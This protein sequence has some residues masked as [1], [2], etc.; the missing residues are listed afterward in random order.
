[1]NTYEHFLTYL[2]SVEI[3]SALLLAALLSHLLLQLPAVRSASESDHSEGSNTPLILQSSCAG[4]HL[5]VCTQKGSAVG[6]LNP[7]AHPSIYS[8]SAHML[9]A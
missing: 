2:E 8:D 5:A 6:T 4:A 7:D 9:S 3:L 1:M